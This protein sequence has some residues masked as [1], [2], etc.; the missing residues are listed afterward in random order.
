VIFPE[1]AFISLTQAVN[2]HISLH[3]IKPRHDS[4]A[5]TNLDQSL[6][7]QKIEPTTSNVMSMTRHAVFNCWTMM[8]VFSTHTSEGAEFTQTI[9]ENKIHRNRLGVPR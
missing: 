5:D 7:T 3:I 8:P 6:P 9:H 2:M 4:F 1:H